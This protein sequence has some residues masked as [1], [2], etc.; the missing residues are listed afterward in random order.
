MCGDS[1]EAF[2]KKL[3]LYKLRR[4]VEI[5]QTDLPVQV[6]GATPRHEKHEIEGFLK[7]RAR[8]PGPA[9]SCKHRRSI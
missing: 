5:T 4:D 2:V 3:N 9:V 8:P 1:A 7:T 6:V